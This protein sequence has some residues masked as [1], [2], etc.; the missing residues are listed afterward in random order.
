MSPLQL[1]AVMK[2]LPLLGELEAEVMRVAWELGRVAVKDVAAKLKR[3]RAYNTVQTTLE[4]LYRKSLL[5]K[6]KESHAFIYWP[7]IDRAEYH[8]EVLSG[9][10]GQ[11]LPVGREPV[12]A[13]FVE[14]A[15]DDDLENLE[16]LEGLIAAKRKAER[17][18]K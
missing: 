14:L 3:P 9:L 4:R 16:R 6:E 2:G 13:A 15:A 5:S 17:A 12:L 8:R 18:R 11:L 10:V 1:G 7:R